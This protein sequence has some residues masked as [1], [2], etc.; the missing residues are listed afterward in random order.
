MNEAII[1]RWNAKVPPDATVYI[2][3]DLV[4]NPKHLWMVRHLNGNIQLFLGNH[5]HPFKGKMID[6]Y[7]EVGL[8]LIGPEMQRYVS[9]SG[10]VFNLCHFP[11]T[12]NDPRF[13]KYRPI[14]DGNF[15]LHGHSHS[16]P[17]FKL[18]KNMLDVGVDGNAFTP[19]SISEIEEL[20]Y[21]M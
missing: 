12:N 15:L 20:V 16:H 13:V 8:T 2:L 7:E 18:K 1:E 11:Y 5:D 14:D 4:M 17:E 9:P 19:Y 21:G 6:R 3:G 10:R